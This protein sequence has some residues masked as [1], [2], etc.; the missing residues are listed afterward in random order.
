M[1]APARRVAAL[2]VVW[3]LSYSP[4]V[5]GPGD[6]RGP[7]VRPRIELAG[8][9]ADE[10]VLALSPDGR[11]AAWAGRNARPVI[12]LCDLTPGPERATVTATV[13]DGAG[14]TALC[15]SPDGRDLVGILSDASERIRE[16]LGRR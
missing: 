13:R 11:T 10:V 14:V 1:S 6:G 8:P 3:T 12:V 4:V 2:L 7:I 16:V 5:G 15:F 9:R